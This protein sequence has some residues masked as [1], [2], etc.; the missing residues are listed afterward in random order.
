MVSMIARCLA[1]MV[2]LLLIGSGGCSQ[3]PLTEDAT[4][5]ERTTP[6]SAADQALETEVIQHQGNTYELP[7]TLEFDGTTWTRVEV[8]APE[9]AIG[10]RYEAESRKN[11]LFYR[12]MP[13]G[14]EPR[15]SYAIVEGTGP[16][17]TR[18]PHGPAKFTY[19]DGKWSDF[20]Y[21]YGKIHGTF[22]FYFASGKLSRELEIVKGRRKG[23]GKGYYESGQKHW[24]AEFSNDEPIG[25]TVWDEEGN[26]VDVRLRD[27][28]N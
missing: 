7:A 11:D 25:G 13:K 3:E 12:L 27:V 10:G 8:L 6:V 5:P 15:E 4:L 14:S 19:S 22:K 2:C 26:E 16:F 28:V 9:I 21:D 18:I 17:M 24:E 23:I 20:Q 1:L